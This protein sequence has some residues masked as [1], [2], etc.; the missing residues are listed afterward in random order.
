MDERF[1]KVGDVELCYEPFGA[2]DRPAVL[3]VM[4]LGTQM[5]GWHADFCTAL[6]DRGFYVIRYD[7]RDVGRSSHLGD[8]PAPTPRAIVTRRIRR[9]PYLLADMAADG[10]GLLDQ[11]G[12][13]RAHVVGASMGGMIAQTMAA[14]H[15]DQVLSLVSIMSSTGSR[16]A[17]QPAPRILPVFLQKPAAS[18]ED[19]AERIV[20]L[21]ALV[22]SPGFERD[23]DELRELA[24]T[25]WERGV[26]PAGFA[27][28][29][30]AIIASGHRARDLKQIRV[31][32]LV[33]HGKSD[34]LVRPSGGRATARAIP[35]ARL[36]L[37]DGMGHDLPR[38]VW[39]RV[40]DGIEE[41]AARA[42]SPATPVRS[43]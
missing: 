30:G 7:N 38:G 31:P 41:T 21:F 39:P 20:K 15:P 22:G 13:E 35:G 32:T 5:I 12:I 34:R 14:G 10:V 40:L 24:A 2:P 4:G 16:W 11:L 1:C 36:E 23:D 28:Q 6:A 25:S 37:I 27:R 26:D 19:Y 29:L 9:P 8:R 43:L 42:P 17:G 18:K 33:I 3:L